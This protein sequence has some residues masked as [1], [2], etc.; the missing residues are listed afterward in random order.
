MCLRA[1]GPGRGDHRLSVWMIVMALGT[2]IGVHAQASGEDA[3]SKPET[4]TPHGHFRTISGP[5][6]RPVHGPRSETPNIEVDELTGR[7][8]V[9]TED[10]PVWIDQCRTGTGARGDDVFPRCLV[11]HGGIENVTAN[12]GFEIECSFCHGGD[13]RSDTKEGAHV[14]RTTAPESYGKTIPPLDEDLAYQKFVNPTNLRVVTETCGL[15]H[16]PTVERVKKSMMATAAGHYAGG[17]YQNNVIDTKTPIYGTFAVTD[18]DGVVPFEKGA[19]DALI[20]LIIYD[21][22]ADQSLVATHFAAVPSQ[23]C[24]RCHLWSR[25]KGYRGAVGADGTYRADG[26]AA[27]H[28]PYA[29]NGLSLS[30]DTAIDHTEPGH[31]KYHSITRQI[32]TE[33]CIHCHHRGARIGLNF[34]GRAQMPPRLPSGPGIPGTTDEIFNSNYHY[35][36]G[37]TNPPDVHHELGMHC[38]DCHVGSEI[39]GDGNIYGHMDQATKIECR[40]CHGLPGE[41][42]T[43]QDNDGVP[44]PNIDFVSRGGRGSLGDVVLTSKVDGVQHLTPLAMEFTDPASPSY[45]PRAACAMDDNHIKHEGGLECYACHSA[46]VP[47]CFGC[48]FER[49]ETLEGLNLWTGLMEEGKVNTSNKIFESLRPFSIGPNSEGRVAPYLVACQ[50]I[51]D[52]TAADGSKKLDM[53]M[54]VTANGLSGLAHNP[55]QPHTVR[56]VGEVRT[57]VECHRSPASLGMG[58]GNYSIARERVFAAGSTGVSVYDRNTD[59]GQPVPDGSLS[60]VSSALGIASIANTVEG[61][62]DYLFI[63]RGVSGVDIFDRR[64]GAPAAAV[65][66][67]TGVNAIDV[68]RVSRY[69]YVADAGTGI[70]IYDNDIPETASLI[71]TVP[72][73][74]VQRVVPW[75]IHLLVAAGEDGLV[76]VNIADHSAPYIEKTVSRI[77]AVDVRAYA[78]YQSGSAFAVR[79]YVADPDYG[80]R[81]VDLLP[82]IDRARVVDELSVPG[83]VGLDSYTRWVDATDTE[84]SREHDYLYVVAGASGLFIYDMTNP[85]NVFQVAN[86]NGL[87]GSVVDVDVSSHLAPPGTDDYAVLANESLGLQVVNVNDPTQP[88]SLGTVPGSASASRVFTEVQQMDR[89]LDEQ[90]NQLKENSHPFTGFFSHDDIVR[91]LSVS[92]QCDTLCSPEAIGDA[93][94]DGSISVNDIS[95]VLQRLGHTGQPCLE[96]DVNGDGLV[97]VN[98][99]SYV[100]FRLGSV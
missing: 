92:V 82:D 10:G 47:N 87:G 14:P 65:T 85:Q 99:I 52:V 100:L 54:P 67:I 75:G 45:N 89:F 68:S 58:T 71:A 83:A 72:I 31:P 12:M 79:A 13:P 95:F 49:N 8:R 69:L 19:V 76:I 88:V 80:V 28:M 24:A 27:C 23:G 62:A 97:D 22:N 57:C 4:H 40:S 63:A 46:W 16:E 48:H 18:D 70:R 33:Q 43:L 74:G 20:D 6:T 91:I 30:A 3:T 55:V 86:V 11:C 53:V 78:H 9:D 37:D 42:P 34:T 29:N 84:P 15:C 73:P 60:G 36:V 98:D 81:I 21:P 51:A 59:P 66:T 41:A 1:T 26:C 38:I 77:N 64:P 56:G 61:T 35:T 25:G 39:M 5:H 96:G 50:P 44:L 90:G 32:P 93:N 2:S 94:G 7:I 17:L